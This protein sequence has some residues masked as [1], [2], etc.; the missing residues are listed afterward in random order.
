MA[1]SSPATPPSPETVFFVSGEGGR[2]NE[3]SFFDFLEDCFNLFLHLV[4][5][6]SQYPYPMRLQKL[7]PLGIARGL[8]RFSVNAA[9]QLDGESMFY[10]KEIQDKT[11]IGM[12]S[13]EFQAGQAAGS[14]CVPQ[15]GFS[16]SLLLTQ[17]TRCMDDN[18]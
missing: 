18:S 4:I 16:V 5:L 1:P 13:P 11:A 15:P 10:A 17:F 2:G 14:Q 9:V 7:G 3:A 8:R 6:E 12:L